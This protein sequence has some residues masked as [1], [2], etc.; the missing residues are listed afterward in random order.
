VP[1]WRQRSLAVIANPSFA[2]I[3]MMICLDGLIFEF[4]SPGF[5]VPGV[6]GAICLLLGLFALPMDFLGRLLGK[7]APAAGRD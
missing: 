7:D 4:M 5:G 2:L 3:L 6:T 1:D